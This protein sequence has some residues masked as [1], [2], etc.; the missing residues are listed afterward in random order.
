MKEKKSRPD[1]LKDVAEIGF[2][3]LASSLSSARQIRYTPI[4]GVIEHVTVS[5]P[6]GC[7][8][9][10]EVLFEHKRVQIIPYPTQGT[11]R[12]IALDNFTE[13]LKP[14]WPVMH[15]D[16]IEMVILNHDDTYDHTISALMRIRETKCF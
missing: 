16:A 12:G 8:F 11:T 14:N 9:L 2:L 4:S 7:N 10:V 5:W 1:G 15:G 13:T 3:K 6:R